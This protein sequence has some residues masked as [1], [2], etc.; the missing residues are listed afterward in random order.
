MRASVGATGRGGNN[1]GGGRAIPMAAEASSSSSSGASSMGVGGASYNSNRNNMESLSAHSRRG[2]P[3]A[4]SAAAMVDGKKR[5]ASCPID[6]SVDFDA[7]TAV[8]SS[9]EGENASWEPALSPSSW[10]WTA[11]SFLAAVPLDQDR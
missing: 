3:G 2:E 4:G 11:G 5:R 8:V 9:V 6:D 10:Y 1:Q 7:R